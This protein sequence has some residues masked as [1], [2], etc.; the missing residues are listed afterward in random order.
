MKRDVGLLTRLAALAIL[1]LGMAASALYLYAQRQYLQ[2]AA[3]GDLSI[4][5]HLQRANSLL[6]GS[7][8][9]MVVVSAL[10]IWL[11]GRQQQM[12]HDLAISEAQLRHLVDTMPVMLEAADDQGRIV[13][14]NQAC[15]DVTGYSAEIMLQHPKPL[16]LLYPDGSY[17][18]S[19]FSRPEERGRGP[20]LR[21]LTC[22]DGSKRVIAWRQ[23]TSES[24]PS[25]WAFV[26]LGH[27]VT[28]L[29]Q[30]QHTLAAARDRYQ[31]LVDNQTDYIARLGPRGEIQFAS[32]S[33]CAFANRP[34]EVLLG[35][36]A[37]E[38][39][40]RRG[41]SEMLAQ[42]GS[43]TRK[44]PT[45]SLEMPIPTRNGTRIIAWAATA[46]FDDDSDR[47]SSFV[48]LGRD[49]TERSQAEEALVESQRQLSTLMA[50][51]PGMAYRCD[52]DA[53]WTMRFVSDGCAELTGY[54][55][56]SL[57]ANR[58]LS[59]VSLIEIQDRETVRQSVTDAIE[60]DKPFELVYRIRT[61]EGQLKW[62][63][64]KGRAVLSE[65]G[66]V[67]AL[68]GFITDISQ[69]IRLEEQLR[70]SQKMEV[71]G[72]LAGGI[73]HD[74]NNLLTVING[75]AQIALD[76][77]GSQHA[78]FDDLTEVRNAGQRAADLTRRLLAFSRRE[79]TRKRPV[80]LNAVIRDVQGMV[81]R[82]VGPQI[83]VALE[84]ASEL[85]TVVADPAQIE[86]VLLNLATN[87]RDAMP[88]GGQILFATK[89]ATVTLEQ[90]VAGGSLTP[91][92]YVRLL[93]VDSGE[94]LSPEV[95][96]HLFEPFY[97]TKEVG[98]GTGLGLAMVYGIV[99]E[100]GGVIDVH[101][102]PKEGTRFEVYLP[103]GDTPAAGTAT[104]AQTGVAKGSETI[105][106]V[107]PDEQTCTFGSN[108]LK[109]LGYTVIAAWSV[110]EALEACQSQSVVPDL[111]LIDAILGG[112]AQSSLQAALS[113]RDLT[114]PLLETRDQERYAGS[115]GVQWL[116]KPFTL[117]S[118]AREVRR[119]L[120]D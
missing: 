56:E 54:P 91:G 30:A 119:A 80:D 84:L 40:S 112:E 1:I 39:V 35:M 7:C 100:L 86:R 87:A 118:L 103:A 46:L 120:G 104:R 89:D 37:L 88:Q 117:S 74:F 20:I 47:P 32:P 55:P 6:L 60:E 12:R 53:D 11:Y 93:V 16:E 31:L 19:V 66:S 13:V 75:Y 64:E 61:R 111:I 102:A 92:R 17:H 24:R 79:P 5:A 58:V 44:N 42:F 105:L 115:D 98:K 97:T 96:D 50:N 4:I 101:S 76:T 62:V 27:D 15:K 52:H 116:A 18:H 77:L 83:G 8:A 38:L 25:D 67:I 10:L 78:L 114:P 29:M 23:L 41:G 59:Y 107:E 43:M 57:L 65:A 85:P 109:H 63:W 71:V 94:G 36:N 81:E 95:Q 99:Q 106:L 82:L 14:W 110:E 68:E 22:A 49:I 90:D 34:E 45:A 33:F 108:M 69:R 72:R 73:A 113:T 48:V 26:G 28:P 51:L 21:E 70:Q 9:T 3:T 2:V